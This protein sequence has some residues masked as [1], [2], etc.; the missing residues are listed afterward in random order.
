MIENVTLFQQGKRCKHDQPN[1]ITYLVICK[2][3]PRFRVK[4]GARFTTP[5]LTAYIFAIFLNTS[6]LPAPSDFKTSLA[7]AFST[8]I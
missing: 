2:R 5:K 1:R 7:S 4:Y 6:H 8:V 3:K